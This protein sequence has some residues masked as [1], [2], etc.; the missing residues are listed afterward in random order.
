MQALRKPDVQAQPHPFDDADEV[1]GWSELRV[2]GGNGAAQ[3]PALALRDHLAARLDELAQIKASDAAVLALP[4]AVKLPM[5]ARVAVIVG[6]SLSLWGAL[7]M[8][9]SA[10]L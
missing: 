6:L 5:A 3:S 2:H 1:R 10:M 9:V 7:Y 8:G 4:E